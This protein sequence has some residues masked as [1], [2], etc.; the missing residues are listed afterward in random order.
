MSDL[1][2]TS[3]TSPGLRRKAHSP[4][5]YL[6]TIQRKFENTIRVEVCPEEG[7]L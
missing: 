2:E 5:H 3:G 4:R 1:F 7:V 6:S